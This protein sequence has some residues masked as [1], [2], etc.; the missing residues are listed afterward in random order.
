MLSIPAITLFSREEDRSTMAWSHSYA[1]EDCRVIAELALPLECSSV[2]R[3]SPACTV[4]ACA[5]QSLDPQRLSIGHVHDDDPSELIN[6]EAVYL[7]VWG[8]VPKITVQQA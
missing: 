7:L 2:V 4:Y 1:L 6:L 5:P 8:D 3:E